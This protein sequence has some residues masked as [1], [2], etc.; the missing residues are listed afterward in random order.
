[1]SFLFKPRPKS[2]DF[3]DESVKDEFNVLKSTFTLIGNK[4]GSDEFLNFLYGNNQFQVFSI[5]RNSIS[6][7]LNVYVLSDKY[8]ESKDKKDMIVLPFKK[9]GNAWVTTICDYRQASR[10]GFDKMEGEVCYEYT[11]M[12]ILS[13]SEINIHSLPILNRDVTIVNDI[14]SQRINVDEDKALKRDK[15]TTT[16]EGGKR[17]SRRG[18]KKYTKK[19]RSKTTK[20]GRRK[21]RAY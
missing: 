16:S 15:R 12:P 8:F 18:I 21:G 7:N 14:V 4:D 9:K 19:R 20:K 10:G 17:K 6:G 11:A 5:N 1:M 13:E 3:E 2:F